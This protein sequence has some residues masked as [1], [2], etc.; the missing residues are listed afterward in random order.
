VA[1]EVRELQAFITTCHSWIHEVRRDASALTRTDG[2][3]DGQTDR[4]TDRQRKLGGVPTLHC[5]IYTLRLFLA[6]SWLSG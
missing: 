4:Q 2:R 6:F 1:L 3:T 5:N